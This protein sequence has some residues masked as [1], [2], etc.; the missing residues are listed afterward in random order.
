MCKYRENG[1]CKI[2]GL[3]ANVTPLPVVDN[4]CLYCNQ[5]VGPVTIK[6]AIEY[7]Q[8]HYPKSK[9][10]IS[11]EELGHKKTSGP[12]TTLASILRWFSTSTCDCKK[13]AQIMDAWG[14]DVCLEKIETILGWL[15]ESARERNLPYVDFVMRAVVHYSIQI[16][17]I[18]QN[19]PT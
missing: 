15:K 11:L 7:L 4:D 18:H 2:A 6:V 10:I 3:L 19:P 13:Y 8:R 5:D 12:G 16:H 17:K 9:L 14:P 1:L